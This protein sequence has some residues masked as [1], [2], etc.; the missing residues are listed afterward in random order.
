MGDGVKREREREAGVTVV[1]CCSWR[2]R[3]EVV[4]RVFVEGDRGGEDSV[5]FRSVGSGG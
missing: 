1:R 2:R 5:T 4:Y 3:I